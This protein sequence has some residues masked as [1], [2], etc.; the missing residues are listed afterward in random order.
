MQKCAS[1]LHNAGYQA[2]REREES[3]VQNS[4]KLSQKHVSS[5]L[6]SISTEHL[7]VI[8]II[9]VQE[10]SGFVII[11]NCVHCNDVQHAQPKTSQRLCSKMSAWSER[12]LVYRFFCFCFCFL[13]LCTYIIKIYYLTLNIN[14]LRNYER[15][16][17]KLNDTVITNR[18]T[19]VIYI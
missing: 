2:R 14:Y 5:G 8:Q 6:S 19:I 7:I 12:Y 11:L 3:D 1:S 16:M 13:S 18:F 15:L 9:V 17:P 10:Y 4:S